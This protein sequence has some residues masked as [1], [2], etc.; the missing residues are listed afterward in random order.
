MTT[1]KE[2]IKSYRDMGDDLYQ[3]NFKDDFKK[4]KRMVDSNPMKEVKF[5]GGVVWRD[6]EKQYHIK[7]DRSNSGYT[8]V[9]WEQVPFDILGSF[10]CDF[11][12]VILN[13]T[14]NRYQFK[15]H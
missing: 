15:Q 10:E 5:F 8:V 12:N 1:T 4:L 11:G 7:F 3:S 13:G 2:L 14:N 9:C 6:D